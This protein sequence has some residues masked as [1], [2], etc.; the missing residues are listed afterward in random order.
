MGVLYERV[1]EHV[2][3][4]TLNRPDSLNA[5]DHGLRRDLAQMLTKASADRSVRTVVLTGAGRAFCAGADVKDVSGEAKVEDI[6]NVEYA[7]FLTLVATMEKPVIAAVNGPAAGI[8]LTLALS[9]DLRVMAEDAYMMSA[10]SNI[11]L[12]PDGG[13]SWLLTRQIGYARAYQVAIEAE[14][15]R[16][17][18]ALDWGLANR[19]ARPE[20][21][22]EETLAWAES[23]AARAPLALAATKRAFR[24]ADQQGLRNA[25]AYE[26]Q[27]QG[28][29]IGTHD[30]REGV[31]A[32]LEKRAPAF[33]GE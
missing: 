32:L 15:I 29:L 23:L 33:K 8:G 24:A 28:A 10:F 12:V 14:K 27:L 1:G 26:A 16:A 18:Q 31:T 19:I 9:C 17:P 4:I 2:A 13:L 11:G 22:V 21:L 25:A 20:K 5:F 3:L 30:C 7:A 6:L